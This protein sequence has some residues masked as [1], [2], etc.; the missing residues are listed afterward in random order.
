MASRYDVLTDFL[1]K[2]NN[3]EISLSFGQVSEIVG[4]LRE[5]YY[6]HDSP[7]RSGGPIGSAAARAGYKISLSG[8]RALFF[9]DKANAVKNAVTILNNSMPVKMIATLGVEEALAHIRK[10]HKTTADGVHTRY[11]SWE[12]CY[13][14]F[15]KL[16]NDPEK[17]DLLC[18]HLS[19]YLLSWGMFRNSFLRNFDFLVHK[20]AVIELTIDKFNR[21]LLT[22]IHRK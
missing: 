12:H 7:W 16:H 11:R 22:N 19:C 5:S 8:Q 9:K 2:N 17:I 20:T 10:Y 13:T 3:D 15:C 4:G 21:F 1:S 14:A 6:R 18:L